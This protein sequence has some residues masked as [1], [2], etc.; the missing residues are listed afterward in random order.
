MLNQ[1]PLSSLSRGILLAIAVSAAPAANAGFVNFVADPFMG[2]TAGVDLQTSAG[3][4]VEIAGIGPGGASLYASHFL[5]NNFSPLLLS[6]PTET[7]SADFH[8][9]FLDN[10]GTPVGASATLHTNAFTVDFSANHTAP[11]QNG[12][13]NLILQSATF[14]GFIGGS[15]PLA[16]SLANIPTATVVISNHA[17]GGFD[18]DYSTPFSIQGQYSVN[19]GPN[20]PTPPLGDVNGGQPTTPNVPEPALLGMAIT[21]MLAMAGMRNNR[22]RSFAYPQVAAIQA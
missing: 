7:F 10:L 18:I 3:T 19:N 2:N 21:G 12:T 4:L 5:I 14:T 9:D 1:P 17:G 6:G 13:F 20:V 16:V 15:T 22:R 11:F 8:V